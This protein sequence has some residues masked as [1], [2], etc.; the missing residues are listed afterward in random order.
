MAS[1][2]KAPSSCEW[3]WIT[4]PALSV[5]S[6]PMVTRVFSGKAQPSSKSLRPTRTPTSR[7]MMALNGVPVNSLS[8][9]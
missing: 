7:N 2:L 1:D 4:L 9:P 3:H 5:Q 8:S 6:S